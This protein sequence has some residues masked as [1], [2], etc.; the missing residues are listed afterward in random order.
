M[1]PFNDCSG[2]MPLHQHHRA[3]KPYMEGQSLTRAY[4]AFAAPHVRK[5]V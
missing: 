5:P 4:Q 1:C 2:D 3:L